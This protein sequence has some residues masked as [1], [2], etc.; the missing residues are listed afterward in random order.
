MTSSVA[1][2]LALLFAFVNAGKFSLP[3]Y[4]EI[5]ARGAGLIH[6]RHEAGGGDSQRPFQNAEHPPVNTN[7]DKSPALYVSLFQTPILR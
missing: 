4:Q 3:L 1:F 7:K 6:K 5:N 2:V